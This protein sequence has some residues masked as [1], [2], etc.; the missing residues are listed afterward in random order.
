MSFSPLSSFPLIVAQGDIPEYEVFRKFANNDA[1]GTT[2]EVVHVTGA[3]V[4]YHPTSAVTLE[5]I[6][7]STNDIDTTGTYARTVLVYGLDANFDLITETISLNGTSA[8]SATSNSFIRVYR[9]KVVSVGTYG[10]A[11]EGALTIRASGAGTTFV[12]IRA[13]SGQTNTS[14]YTVPTGKELYITGVNFTVETAKDV[15]F[16]LKTRENADDVSSPFTSVRTINDYVGL[17]GNVEF[18]Y[19]SSPIV[20]PAK[21]DIWITAKTST[22]TSAGSAEYLGILRTL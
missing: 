8:S 11:N 19:S 7:T 15:S 4:P 13:G 1:I 20:I 2:E 22:G 17:D 6:S 12:T 5:A 3:A 18:D 21:T 16:Y 10:V 14:T 9:A